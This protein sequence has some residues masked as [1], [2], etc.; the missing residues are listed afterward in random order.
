MVL[1]D[2]WDVATWFGEE[3]VQPALRLGI[4]A[5]GKETWRIPE[6]YKAYKAP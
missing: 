4:G 6:R 3:E 2:L 5:G 1:L